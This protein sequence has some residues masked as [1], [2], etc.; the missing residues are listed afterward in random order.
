MVGIDEIGVADPVG[1]LQALNSCAAF[2]SN[3]GQRVSLLDPVH[4]WGGGA[5]YRTDTVLIGVSQRVTAQEMQFGSTS[6]KLP[7]KCNI[8]HGTI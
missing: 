1:T 8:E 3:V 5:A 4:S 7:I 6:F 2:V